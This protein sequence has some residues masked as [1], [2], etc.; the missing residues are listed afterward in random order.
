MSPVAAPSRHFRD[1]ARLLRDLHDLVRAGRGDSPEADASREMMDE[2]WEGLSPDEAARLRGLSAD[3]GTI[4]SDPPETV[5]RPP[6]ASFHA[7]LLELE[8]NGDWDRLLL[9]LRSHREQLRA[10]KVAVLRGVC[11]NA[12]GEP[13]AAVQ[14]WR[15]SIRLIKRRLERGAS[16][17]MEMAG[18]ARQIEEFAARIDERRAEG[19]GELR[20]GI[21]EFGRLTRERMEEA[22]AC[23]ES[24]DEYESRLLGMAAPEAAVDHDEAEDRRLS[25]PPAILAGLREI[26][27]SLDAVERLYSPAA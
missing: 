24:L 18:E 13:L 26:E 10:S 23:E 3:L 14:F 6:E 1:Y 4:G 5:D 2:A 19:F 27:I 11:W 12:L 15:E 21:E 25:P 16:K 7:L 9:L 20:R 22:C 8:Q 17:L